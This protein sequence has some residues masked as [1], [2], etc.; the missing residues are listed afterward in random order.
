MQAVILAPDGSVKVMSA[1]QRRELCRQRS[2]KWLA[3]GKAKHGEWTSGALQHQRKA[4]KHPGGRYDLLH[5]RLWQRARPSKLS[6][7]RNHDAALS[8]TNPLK[9]N[10]GS[11]E[12]AML[13]PS[14]VNEAYVRAA[15]QWGRRRLSHSYSRRDADLS[16]L[17]G[18][19]YARLRGRVAV[20]WRLAL[21]ATL[22]PAEFHFR[23]RPGRDSL[24]LSTSSREKHLVQPVAVLDLER[25]PLGTFEFGWRARRWRP[26]SRSPRPC[27][28]VY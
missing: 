18:R 20:T 6:V 25:N 3:S 8:G 5:S 7:H 28:R 26:K 14:A 4:A 24:V 16:R 1:Q 22:G 27:H 23:L 2:A 9:L 11:G 15:G 21:D 17:S 10:G 19:R 12:L 13:V